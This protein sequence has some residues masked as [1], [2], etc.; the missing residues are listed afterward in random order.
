MKTLDEDGFLNLIRSREGA[1]LDEKQI[2]ALEKQQKQIEEAA[3]EMEAREKEEEKLAKRKEAAMS[4]T[5]LAVKCA[6]THSSGCKG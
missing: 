1:E 2:K 5:G 4:G 6:P 3:K